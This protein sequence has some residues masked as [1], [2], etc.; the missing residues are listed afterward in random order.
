[1]P[2]A[3]DHLVAD[4]FAAEVQ[5][6]AD[7]VLDARVDVVVGAHGAA[8]LA[9]RGVHRD[10]AHALQ[11]A[12]D[13]E[14]PD[15][16]LHAE[17][18]GLGVDAVRAPDLD[19]VAELERP[20]LEYLAQRDEVALQEQ[21]GLLDLQRQGGVEHVAAGHAVVHVLAGVAD[22]LGDVGEEGDDVVVGRLLDL[23]DAG[24]VERGLLLDLADGV[25]GDPAELVP[26]LHGGD[27]HVE[28]G[29]HPGLVGPDRAHLRERVALDHRCLRGRRRHGWAGRPPAAVCRRRDSLTPA[30]RR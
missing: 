30:A 8:D 17:R 26:G 1:M 9:D 11:V 18:D 21:A 28:P 14:R 16:E 29:L 27:L 19:R 2:V 15:A 24:D 5:L 3:L 20:P 4:R 23:V 25:V 10:H 12:A 7:Q 6:L 22:V 13:L